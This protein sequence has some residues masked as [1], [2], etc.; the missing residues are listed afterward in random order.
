NNATGSACS[1]EP[2]TV[3][4]AT[5]TVATQLSATSI[6]AGGSAHD[7][8]TLTGAAGAAGT[9][10]YAVYSDNVCSSLAAGLQPSPATVSV[11]NGVAPSSAGVTFPSAGTFYW[12]AAYSGDSGHNAASSPC[13]AANN[14]LLNVQPTCAS[15]GNCNS[16]SSSSS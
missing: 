13:T 16:G 8:A 2:L 12:Q 4:K 15:L 10:T 9:V 11:S 3:V 14:E 6:L 1:A 5:P 7:S